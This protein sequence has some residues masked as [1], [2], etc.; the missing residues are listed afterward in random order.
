[1]IAVKYIRW[2]WY[3]L[4]EV[5][6]SAGCVLLI[7]LLIPEARISEFLAKTASDWISV[8]GQVLFP[9]SVAVLTVYANMAAGKFGEYLH[10]QGREKFYLHGFTWPVAIFALTTVCL[11]FFKGGDEVRCEWLLW[12]T[13]FLLFWSAAAGLTMIANLLQIV[14]L[15]RKFQLLLEEIE[16]K[17]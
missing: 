6:L 3:Y 10:K 17:K 2:A 1:M 14:R 7:F 9:A 16:K 8:T 12:G 11:I 4:A 5:A 13:S 15:F